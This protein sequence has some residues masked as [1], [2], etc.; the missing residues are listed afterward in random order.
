MRESKAERFR[1][2]AEASVNK[3]IKMIRLLG[4]CANPQTYAYDAAQSEKIFAALQDELGAAKERFSSAG[5][6]S[7][8][9]FSLSDTSEP[10]ENALL[11]QLSIQLPDGTELRATAYTVF[12]CQVKVCLTIRSFSSGSHCC[13]KFLHSPES[14]RNWYLKRRCR[15]YGALCSW[16]SILTMTQIS[17]LCPSF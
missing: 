12:L 7:K 16:A 3:T 2:V 13:M 6:S 11:P 9:R 10:A 17:R 5:K 15:R 14:W 1:R 4:N 8:K